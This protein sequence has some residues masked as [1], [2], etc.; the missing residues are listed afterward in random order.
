M[1]NGCGLRVWCAIVLFVPKRLWS[2]AVVKG[3]GLRVWCAVVLFV[4]K[5]LWSSAVVCRC[6]AQLCL[7]CQTLVVYD[8]FGLWCACVVP[9][10][11]A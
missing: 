1:V 10:K 9:C 4:P 7:L 5:W 8:E 6:G 2:K 11:N 3:C